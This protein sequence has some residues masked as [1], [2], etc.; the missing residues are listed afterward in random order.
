MY[1]IYMYIYIYIYTCMYV[2]FWRPT[3][4]PSTTRSR[5]PT[6]S[7][8]S[9]ACWRRAPQLRG[10]GAATLRIT[11]PAQWLPLPPLLL[12]SLPPSPLP[13]A[14]GPRSRA[15]ALAPVASS[16]ASGGDRC[17]FRVFWQRR[18]SFAPCSSSTLTAVAGRVSVSCLGGKT[19]SFRP[20][21]P[22]RVEGGSG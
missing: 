8:P 18:P 6:S 1:Y 11:P 5:T 7:E 9:T 13:V 10:S 14:P 16:A 12:S 22:L 19:P 4:S 21:P 20:R 2:I 17:A 15:L 3:S